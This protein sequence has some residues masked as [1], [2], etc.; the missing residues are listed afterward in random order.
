MNKIK[1]PIVAALAA[2]AVIVAA[3][4]VHDF[5]GASPVVRGERR[6]T[7]F[8]DGDTNK[9]ASITT[10]PVVVYQ[11]HNILARIAADTHADNLAIKYGDVSLMMTGY[12]S[13]VSTNVAPIVEATATGVAKG[14]TAAAA[15]K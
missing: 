5:A 15:L 8:L 1:L 12:N 2:V 9:V 14:I 10:E 7:T 6:I 13:V 4:C 3:G 11:W